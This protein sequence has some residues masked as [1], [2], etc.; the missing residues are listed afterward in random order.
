MST[1]ERHTC[2]LLTGGGGTILQRN[3]QCHQ[4]V[5][6]IRHP[7]LDSPS[8]PPLPQ[9]LWMAERGWRCVVHR[10]LSHPM[11][12]VCAK[13]RLL[14]K[15]LLRHLAGH[16]DG[17]CWLTPSSWPRL[18]MGIQWGQLDSLQALGML[19]P[20]PTVKGTCLIFH[21]IFQS[22]ALLIFPPPHG[23]KD[24]IYAFNP[25]RSLSAMIQDHSLFSIL[26][27]HAQHEMKD[28]F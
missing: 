8:A 16:A 21:W 26:F 10:L 25:S 23:I 9:Q 20:S 19:L 12:L 17:I 6:G 3:R 11:C 1:V 18:H 14:A 27:F 15:A 4:G 5:V 28:H 7:R 22:V 13:F 2:G 24:H